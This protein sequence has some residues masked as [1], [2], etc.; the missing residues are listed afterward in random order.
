MQSFLRP[1]RHDDARRESRQ[2]F[3]S[4]KYF[5]GPD[6]RYIALSAGEAKRLAEYIPGPSC[7]SLRGR[8]RGEERRLTSE[9]LVS[10]EDELEIALAVEEEAVLEEAYM[11]DAGVSIEI[12]T[13]KS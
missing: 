6:K 8:T 3:G 5:T 4:C 10:L 7:C 11:I 9:G 12:P 1:G 2:C 13:G